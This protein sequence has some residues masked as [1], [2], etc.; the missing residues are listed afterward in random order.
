[1][2]LYEYECGK[3]L[4]RFE[5]MQGFDADSVS[6]CPRCEGSARRIIHPTPLLFKGSGFYI[7]DNR[8]GKEPVSEKGSKDREPVSEKGKQEAATGEK[9][10]GK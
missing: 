3:C 4:Y 5:L 2:P 10:K 6:I 1:M 9:E 7:T 8:K